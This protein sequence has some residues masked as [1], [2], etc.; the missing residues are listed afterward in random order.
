M[1]EK[2]IWKE[3][4]EVRTYETDLNGRWKPAAFYRAMEEATVH[5][6]A[7]LKVDFFTLQQYGL[8][9]VLARSKTKFYHFPAAGNQLL[10]KT[11][12]KGWSQKIFG[13]RDYTITTSDGTVCALSTSAWLLIDTTSRHFVKPERLPVILPDNRGQYALDE[14]LEKLAHPAGMQS[15]IDFKARYSSLDL[16]GHVN[17]AQYIDWIL[18]CF[19]VERMRKQKLDWLQI[20]FNNEVK[21]DETLTIEMSPLADQPDCY[22]VRGSNQTNDTIAFDAQFGW[23]KV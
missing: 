16:M 19:P 23:V 12:P 5:H 11:W 22:S 13:M 20:N 10:V 6:S 7:H 4:G 18:D 1:I 21:P 9:W 3:T 17:N 14:Q 8:A 2:A 15:I